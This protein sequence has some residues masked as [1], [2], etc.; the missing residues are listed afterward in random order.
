MI[1]YVGIWAALDSE[2]E[3]SLDNDEG[4]RRASEKQ[5]RVCPHDSEA[6]TGGDRATDIGS[7]SGFSLAGLLVYFN[8]LNVMNLL[9]SS[10]NTHHTT[11][12][13]K[14]Q[15]TQKSQLRFDYV[16]LISLCVPK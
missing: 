15:K 10:D 3:A 5:V 2:R 11:A 7:I 14:Q 16:Y 13:S 4:T 6:S 1:G 8:D 9:K 12:D